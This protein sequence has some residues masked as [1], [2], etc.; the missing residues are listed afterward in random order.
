MRWRFVDRIEAFESWRTIRGVK[1]ISFEEL[2]LLKRFGREGGL[3][4][5]LIIEHCA[6][7]G[8]WLVMKSSDF[9]RS[10]VLS[11]VDAFS[12]ATPAETGDLL[13]TV[14]EI[15]DR[16]GDEVTLECRVRSKGRTVAEGT[17]AAR[18]VPLTDG[19]DRSAVEGTW[20]ELHAAT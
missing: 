14:A 5:C 7:L 3:P 8:R 2:S 18:L 20:N 9:E 15:Q 13:R 11:G 12:F 10:A 19:F 6:E 4:E 17:L 16:K 1:A